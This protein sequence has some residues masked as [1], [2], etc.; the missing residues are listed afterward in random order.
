MGSNVWGEELAQSYDRTS[1]SMFDPAVLDP[2]V[3]MLA[4]LARGGPALELAV[5]TGRV[6]LPLSVR[7]IEV[8]GI[9]LSPHMAHQLRAKPGAEAVAVTVGDM[10]TTRLE[11]TFTLVYVVWNS[12]M[13]VTTLDDQIAVFANA[14]AHL[15]PGGSFVVEV[16]VPSL[17]WFP[18][19]VGR[20]FHLDREHVGLD[21]L[22]DPVEQIT[23]S[24]HWF[25]VEGHLVHHAAPY[26][27]IWPSEL[28]LMGRL[29][30]FR[31]RD[32]WASW[33]REPF[34]ADSTSQVAMFEKVA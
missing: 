23:S 7:G 1:A 18:G 31:L 14:A 30:G 17:H 9:E 12:I 20:V 16:A 15:E 32:R 13:N 22:D 10:T 6:A 5:G 19:E 8:A 4:E 24:H 33:T 2:A 11:G 21:T 25:D 3:D 27:Y 28:D 26:R 34:T 29:T